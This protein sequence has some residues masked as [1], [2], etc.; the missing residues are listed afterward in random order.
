MLK[1]SRLWRRGYRAAHH[2]NRRKRKKDGAWFWGYITYPDC[3]VILPD[4]NGNPGKA[5]PLPAL[6]EYSCPACG[7][8][9]VKRSGAKGEFYGCSGYPGCKRICP[10]K[11]DGS[12]D[13]SEK[14]KKK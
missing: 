12:P 4:D 1:L 5:K 13:F 11:P 6:S 9:L 2:L 14:S 8:P 7:K 10:V 3:P